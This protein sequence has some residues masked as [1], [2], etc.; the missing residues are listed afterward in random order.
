MPT[1]GR[2]AHLAHMESVNKQG[3]GILS[4]ISES[5]KVGKGAGP[6][7]VDWEA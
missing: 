7:S 5:N 3:K 1:A 4:L 2:I 6:S